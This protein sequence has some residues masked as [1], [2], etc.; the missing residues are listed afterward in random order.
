MHLTTG[1]IGTP[2]LCTVLSQYGYSR[3]AWTLLLNDD[4]PSWLYEVKMG[5]TT[6]WERWNSVL[7]DGRI[8][9][10]GMNSLNHYAYGSIV[11]WMYR[12]MCGINP[13]EDAP[14]YKKI[15]FR[16]EPDRRL[17]WAECELNTA[18][19]RYACGWRFEGDMLKI[20]LSIPL[21]ASRGLSAGTEPFTVSGREY[22]YKI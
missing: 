7:P 11:E 8:S 14:G 17:E 4:Y 19:G 6:I 1:F 22:E 20:K 9:D 12:S 10:T 15:L 3:E 21:I 13:V 2:W 5:A 18:S 16:P